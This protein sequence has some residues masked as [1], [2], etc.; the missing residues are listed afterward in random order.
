MRIMLASDGS[1]DGL[2]ALEQVASL[3]AR[4]G[5]AI[6]TFVVGWPPRSGPLW[7]D[8]Y[9]RQIIADDLHRALEET[10][11]RL[12][13]RLRRIAGALAREVI[14]RV[15]D[16]DAAEQLAAAIEREHIDILFAGLTGGPDR[17]PG[18]RVMDELMARTR[19]PIVAIYGA[20]R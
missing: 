3:R 10:V 17:R 11:E 4:E 5:D 19:I 6:V 14:S 13:E 18:Q 12:S 1:E 16:G 2:N 20:A 9:E 7:R 15:E 8:V